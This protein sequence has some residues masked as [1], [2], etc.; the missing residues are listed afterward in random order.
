MKLTKEEIQ[1]KA[2]CTRLRNLQARI[3]DGKTVTARDKAMLKRL[4]KKLA[5]RK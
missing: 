2:D 3:T 1:N 5:K 4:E